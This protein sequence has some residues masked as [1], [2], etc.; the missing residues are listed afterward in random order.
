[1]QTC[2]TGQAHSIRKQNNALLYH[3]MPAV[4]LRAYGAVNCGGYK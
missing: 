4:L 2:F 3:H 1:M